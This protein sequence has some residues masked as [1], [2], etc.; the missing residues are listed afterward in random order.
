LD[1]EILP[2]YLFY[3][4]SLLSVE[5]IFLQYA[6]LNIVF[7]ILVTATQ[8]L[9]YLLSYIPAV[10]LRDNILYTRKLTYVSTWSTCTLQLLYIAIDILSIPAISDKPERVFSGARRTVSWDRGK[11]EAETLEESRMFKVLETEWYFKQRAW[12]VVF[13]LRHKVLSYSIE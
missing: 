5:I 10:P 3:I 12:R 4:N 13:S 2:R 1:L 11:I 9:L 6:Q 8:L 7:G